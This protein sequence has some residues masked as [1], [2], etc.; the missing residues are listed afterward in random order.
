MTDFWDM[1]SEGVTP[2]ILS[3]MEKEFDYQDSWIAGPYAD[4]ELPR[5]SR[6]TDREA[7]LEAWREQSGDVQTWQAVKELWTQQRFD[8]VTKTHVVVHTIVVAF[9]HNLPLREEKDC[10]SEHAGV[11]RTTLS[12]GDFHS[13]SWG[14]DSDS[15]FAVRGKINGVRFV[16][17]VDGEKTLLRGAWDVDIPSD[18]PVEVAEYYGGKFF[19]VYPY[20]VSS[21][22]YDSWGQRL[23]FASHPWLHPLDFMDESKYDGLMLLCNRGEFRVKKVPSCELLCG[24]EVWEVA[25]AKGKGYRLI[26]PRPG[27]K[28]QFSPVPLSMEITMSE[29]LSTFSRAYRYEVRE[30][31]KGEWGGSISCSETNRGSVVEVDGGVR[32]Q[33]GMYPIVLRGLRGPKKRA[34][35]RTELAP[36]EVIQY[37]DDFM[38]KIP[39][40]MGSRRQYSYIGSKLVV[41]LK[42]TNALAFYAEP[43]KKLD[44]VGGSRESGETP[45]ECLCREILEETQV[46]V[47]PSH[48]QFLGE[49][50]H[51]EETE[52]SVV[53]AKAY[54]YLLV[55]KADDPLVEKMVCVPIDRFDKQS[56]QYQPWVGRIISYVGQQIGAL[57]NLRYLDKSEVVPDELMVGEWMRKYRSISMTVRSELQAVRS[58]RGSYK[59]KQKKKWRNKNDFKSTS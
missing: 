42:D 57:S 11:G 29:V 48:L 10:S 26:R 53:T 31:T 7:L 59:K 16:K 9:S 41:F 14:T 4:W 55:T 45:L 39:E 32:Y 44:F 35:S 28:P 52:K 23:R 24:N 8:C 3:R 6:R 30:R 49:S 5:A 21:F 47:F 51:R 13:L 2:E 43:P 12:W 40:L 22:D 34:D 33:D 58:D 37:G 25:L 27:K 50:D 56:D 17:V 36:M 38:V 15:F 46:T 54:V 18:F 1:L 20:A 19:I